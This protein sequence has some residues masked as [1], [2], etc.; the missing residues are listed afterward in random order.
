MGFALEISADLW[1][2]RTLQGCNF[3]TSDGLKPF[4]QQRVGR[5]LKPDTCSQN[6]AFRAAVNVGFENRPTT[7]GHNHDSIHPLDNKAH[8]QSKLTLSTHTRHG[9]TVLGDCFAT[10]RSKLLTLPP[11]S[12]TG[13]LRAIQ[14]SSSP[15]LSPATAS[16]HRSCVGR[17]KHARYHDP[18]LHARAGHARRRHGRTTPPRISQA[19]GSRLIYLPTLW[20]WP[21]EHAQTNHPHP[22]GRQL[23]AA[24]RR[25]HRR[26][27]ACSIMNASP[28]STSLHSFTST[29]ATS[30][31][32]PTTS[33][34][35]PHATRCKR[36]A[37]WKATATRLHC[38]MQTPT[39]WK[40]HS[41]RCS[42]RLH[43]S[44]TPRFSNGL[45]LR[46]EPGRRAIL[47]ACAHWRTK[48]KS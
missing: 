33:N 37:K 22:F 1:T 45:L 15:G 30:F 48:R 42:M 2:E 35:S 20:C 27:A 31:C 41:S 12:P 40:P 38:F 6:K 25:I 16:L 44:L 36:S 10:R 8:M 19:A 7:A 13:M 47:S 4:L 9:C 28:L 3:Y 43:Q 46:H 11:R 24:L 18:S 21:A 23:H 32:S 29:T 5:I 17:E 34:G 14:M 26:W 39:P